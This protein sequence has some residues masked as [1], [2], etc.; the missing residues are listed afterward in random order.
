MSDRVREGNTVVVRSRLRPGCRLR[1]KGSFHLDFLLYDAL[2]VPLAGMSNPALETLRLPTRMILP[3][4]VMIL[5]SLITRRV[6]RE[7]LDR[8]YVKMKTPVDPD[9]AVDQ[10]ELEASYR[11]PSRFDDRRLS[12]FFG[13]EI[14]RPRLIDLVG[15]GVGFLVCFAIIGLTVWLA[16]L[17]S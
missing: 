10:A 17:G 6:D 4:V 8:Y 9:P 11:D 2:G 13:L 14:Q 16:R 15:F 12:S 3:F 5:L 1:G 7:T